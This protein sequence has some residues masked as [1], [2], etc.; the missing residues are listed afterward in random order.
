MSRLLKLSSCLDLPVPLV[1]GWDE[2]G[3]P[4]QSAAHKHEW[5]LFL[6]ERIFHNAAAMWHKGCQRHPWGPSLEQTKAAREHPSVWTLVGSKDSKLLLVTEQIYR[7]KYTVASSVFTRT[8]QEEL[9]KELWRELSAH[10]TWASPSRSLPIGK[11][12]HHSMGTF[13]LC[14]GV[15]KDRTSWHDAS[16]LKEAKPRKHVWFQVNEELG[17]EPDL[18]ADLVQF[19]AEG[20]RF[21]QQDVPSLITDTTNPQPSLAAS[22]GMAQSASNRFLQPIPFTVQHKARKGEA[23]PHQTS[24]PVDYWRDVPVWEPPSQLVEG[25]QG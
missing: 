10:L 16:L 14:S 4:V 22:G 18:P 17:D 20:T 1:P 24:P 2:E 6:L 5:N 19:L 11:R 21:E 15:T 12:L 8:Q 7:G 9:M 13:E 3:A 25:D 23:R